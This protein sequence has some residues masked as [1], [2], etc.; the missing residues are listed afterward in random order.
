MKRKISQTNMEGM[1]KKA[2]KN[3]ATMME[4]FEKMEDEIY[5]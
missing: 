1:N 4:N 2:K 3:E 5:L